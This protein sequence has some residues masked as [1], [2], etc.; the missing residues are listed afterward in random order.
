MELDTATILS[1]AIRIN[2]LQNLL[3]GQ[4]CGGLSSE[5][6]NDEEEIL[7]ECEEE[8]EE[9]TEIITQ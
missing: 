3:D 5:E 1:Q 8:M 2:E 9:D 4:D 7:I 6:P